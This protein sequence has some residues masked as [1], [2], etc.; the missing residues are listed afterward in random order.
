MKDKRRT[1]AQER[2]LAQLHSLVEYGE[3]HS[4]FWKWRWV[5]RWLP[6]LNSQL[7]PRKAPAYA[8]TV[9]V[10]TAQAL[11]VCSRT[12]TTVGSSG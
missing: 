10:D 5:T 1:E 2:V 3:P 6:A 4:M 9:Y 8:P 7:S 12:W 11:Q